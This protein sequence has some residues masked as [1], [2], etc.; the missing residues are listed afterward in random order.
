MIYAY[1][2]VST[3]K[4]DVQNQKFGILEYC[5][6]RNLKVNAFIEDVVSGKKDWRKREVGSIIERAKEGDTLIFAEISRIS[7]KMLQCLEVLRAC[8]EKKVNVH[9]AKQRMVVDNSMN[10]KIIVWAFSMMA[11]IERELI[12]ARTIEG[13]AKAKSEGKQ[14]GRPKGVTSVNA[15]MASHHIEVQDLLKKGVNPTAIAKMLGLDPRTVRS[16]IKKHLTQYHKTRK[17]KKAA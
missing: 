14:L 8:A 16:Y 2:R 7:R 6:E 13:L 11:E 10:S 15:Q 5:N 4:Q 9:I 3:S 12:S 17:K 1:L